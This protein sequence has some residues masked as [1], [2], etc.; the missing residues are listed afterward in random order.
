MNQKSKKLNPVWLKA[1]LL[2]SVWGSIEIIVGSF[3]HNLRIPF[4]GTILAAIGVCL[5]VAG[6]FIWNDRGLIWRAGLICALMKSISPSAVIIGPMIGIFSEALVLELFVRF[7]RGASIGLL[8]GGGIAVCLPFLQVLIGL[9]ITFGFNIAAIYV[10]LYKFAAKNVG[11]ENLN[12]YDVIGIFV[13]LNAIFGIGAASFGLAVGKKTITGQ[14]DFPILKTNVPAYALQSV[15]AEQK[16]S[17]VLLIVNATM[18]PLTLFVIRDLSLLWSSIF[19]GLYIIIMLILYPR[20]LKRFSKPKIWIEFIVITLLAGLLL[21]EIAN[22]QAGWTWNGLTIG[23]QMCLRASFMIVAFSV[24]SV[25]LRNPKIIDWF[26]QRGF[27]QLSAA[28]EVAFETLPTMVSSL[29]DQRNVLR[30]PI[31]SLSRLLLV[32]KEQLKIFEQERASTCEV[33]ILTGEKG[34]GK[35]TSLYELVKKLKNENY[36]I[37][38]IL[39]TGLWKDSYRFGYDVM[40]IKT[41]EGEPLCRAGSH[42]SGIK[43]G[44]FIFREEGIRFGRTALEISQLVDCDLVIV[45]EVGPLE[46]EGKGWASSLDQLIGRLSCPIL[47]VVRESL[48]KLVADRWKFT[49]PRIR[50]IEEDTSTKIVEQLINHVKQRRNRSFLAS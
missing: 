20:V 41:E 40:N 44:T 11:I 4:A 37:G 16:F 10:E 18:I 6:Q 14:L 30:H 38:G 39:A 47:L 17:I 42:D 25:E 13:L 35:T 19:V 34:S 24:I 31:T 45:D 22:Q 26:F 27:G 9:L 36:T 33:L 28:L 8:I 5:L 15:D 2:G 32:A 7:F 49:S 23:L 48:I 43:V 29:G 46:L 50:K 3:L 1:A 12:A 21:G